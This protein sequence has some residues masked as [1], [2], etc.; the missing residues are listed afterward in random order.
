MGLNATQAYRSLQFKA[1][2]QE[3][4]KSLT[5]KIAKKGRKDRGEQL[6]Q[7]ECNAMGRYGDPPVCE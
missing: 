6:H 7:R 5:T 3:M 4:P 2:F 1:I